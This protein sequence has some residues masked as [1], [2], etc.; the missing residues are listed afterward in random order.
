[1]TQ[2]VDW[3][4]IF[5]CSSSKKQTTRADSTFSFSP[6]FIASGTMAFCPAS[7]TG[8]TVTDNCAEALV[9]E[10][11]RSNRTRVFILYRVVRQT[12]GKSV[13]TD[14]APGNKPL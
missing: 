12:R 8:E 10:V 7:L 1:M 2:R 11:N 3:P 13:F 5:P 6:F 14:G 9:S 4:T